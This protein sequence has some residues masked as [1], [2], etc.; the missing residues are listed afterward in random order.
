VE[1]PSPEQFVVD[2]RHGASRDPRPGERTMFLLSH[3]GDDSL[4]SEPNGTL[5][6][7][8][9]DISSFSKFI[10]MRALR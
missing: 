1:R 2:A 10:D 3:T 9:F 6:C 5:T 8:R 7:R 4:S